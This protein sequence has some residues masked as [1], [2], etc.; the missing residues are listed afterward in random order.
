[1]LIRL[2]KF[3]KKTAAKPKTQTNYFNHNGSDYYSSSLQICVTIPIVLVM[4]MVVLLEFVPMFTNDPIM[5]SIDLNELAFKFKFPTND[6]AETPTNSILWNNNYAKLW[7]WWTKN[8]NL[9]LKINKYD[10]AIFFNSIK[11][12]QLNQS[13]SDLQ[14]IYFKYTS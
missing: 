3:I 2:W 13:N 4:S 7:Q 1:M 9:R 10:P 6:T 8:S 14:S 11:L 5:T 12:Q